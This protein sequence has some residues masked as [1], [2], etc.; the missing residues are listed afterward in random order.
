MKGLLSCLVCS[1]AAGGTGCG[2]PQ[3]AARPAIVGEVEAPP[4]PATSTPLTAAPPEQPFHFDHR[5]HAGKYR[6]PCLTCHTSA[7]HATAAGIPTGDKCM[8]CHRF[9]DSQ[10]P[11]V[12]ALAKAVEL[13]QPIAWNRVHRLPDHV[14]FTHERHVLAGVA[15]QTCH[16]PV[17]TMAVVHQVAPLTMGWCVECHVANRAPHTDCLVCH[18]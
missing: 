16:G 13:G 4:P 1:L 7:D 12:K 15:C 9:V 2:Q 3:P 18:K 5:V 10:K 17:E 14:F 8:G 11:D 6:I